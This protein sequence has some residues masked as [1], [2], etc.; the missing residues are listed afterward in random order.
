MEGIQLN[1]LRLSNDY[2]FGQKYP[3]IFSINR[4][5]LQK[6]EHHGS[7]INVTQRCCIYRQSIQHSFL[8]GPGNYQFGIGRG[9]SEGMWGEGEEGRG[10][11]GFSEAQRF[12]W[13]L[14]EMFLKNWI[15]VEGSL[16]CTKIWFNSL[17]QSVASNS[18]FRRFLMQMK[19]SGS[20]RIR[21][22]WRAPSFLFFFSFLLFYY[23]SDMKTKWIR[24][25]KSTQRRKD[26]TNQCHPPFCCP[27]VALHPTM[28]FSQFQTI[29]GKN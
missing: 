3:S 6:I 24:A 11:Q 7:I 22:N 28:K 19:S 23:H 2:R 17:R 18:S 13:W 16:G 9:S 25:E 27:S 12:L 4:T 29:H 10:I 21:R 14:L 26:E 1:C 15:E 5:R 8:I 20:G